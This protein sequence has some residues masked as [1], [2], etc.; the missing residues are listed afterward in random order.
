MSAC[1]AP[2]CRLCGKIHWQREGC[3]FVTVV[4]A[5]KPGRQ[6]IIATYTPAKANPIILP[7]PAKRSKAKKR[8]AR[9]AKC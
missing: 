5:G 1:D 7:A 2:L 3:Q 9:E 6:Q 8:K 4:K